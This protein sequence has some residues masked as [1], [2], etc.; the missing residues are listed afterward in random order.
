MHAV[1]RDSEREQVSGGRTRRE[2]LTKAAGLAAG[3]LISSAVLPS[4][5]AGA[6]TRSARHA[7][8]LDGDKRTSGLHYHTAAYPAEPY[9]SYDLGTVDQWNPV[10]IPDIVPAGAADRQTL[11]RELATDATIWG[12]ASALQYVQLYQQ[13]ATRA[14]RATPALTPSSIS[15]TSPVRASRPSGPPTSTPCIQTPGWI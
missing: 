15:G 6:R 2:A 7:R 8:H 10:D 11:A 1:E 13:A 12:Y 4:G 3:T 9:P 14:R 5:V